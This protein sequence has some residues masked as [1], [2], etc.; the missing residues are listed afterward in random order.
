[1][2]T[3]ASNDGTEGVHA[4]AGLPLEVAVERLFGLGYR[5]VNLVLTT[6]PGTA[7]GT[8]G[9]W[10]ARVRERQAQQVE[11]TVVFKEPI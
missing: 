5:Q 1:M 3:E 7:A 11:L 2:W 8:G 6:A 4:V 9:L 10:V